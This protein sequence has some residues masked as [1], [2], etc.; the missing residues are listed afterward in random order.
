MSQLLDGW[1]QVSLSEVARFHRGVSYKKNESSDH[2]Q[3]GF[4]PIL[5][6]NNIQNG[7][8]ILDDLVYVPEAKVKETQ[9]ILAGDIVVAMSSGSKRLVGKSGISQKKLNASFGTFCGLLRP[10]DSVDSRYVG[11][12]TRTKYYQDTIS[13]LSKGVNINNLKPKHFDEVLIPLAPKSEQKRVADKLDSIF[14]KMEMAQSRL[15]KVPQL[16]KRFR[17]SVLSAAVAGELTE[18]WRDANNADDWSEIKVT[19]IVEK[20]EAGKNLKCHERPPRED[21]LGIVKISAVTWGVYDEEESKTL[22]DSSLFLENRRI[23]VGDFLISRANTLEL[24]GMPVIVHQVTKNLMLSDK[25][26]RIIAEDADKQWLSIFLRSP[27]GRKQIE[28]RATGNQESMRNIAQKA[29][30]DIDLPMPSPEEKEVIVSIVNGLF[31]K[32]D[33]VEKQYLVAK[34]RVDKLT[35]SILA[36]A[37]RGELFEPFTDKADRVAQTQ[38][39]DVIDEQ[40]AAAE[41]TTL[42]QRDKSLTQSQPTTKAVNDKSE[43]LAQLKSVKNAMTVQQLFESVPGD[44]FK[45]IDELFIEVKRLLE[46]NLVEK[47][48]E[49]ENCQ[50]K[51]TK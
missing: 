28:S 37:F 19:N 12:F 31:G 11:Y 14:E 51:A 2:K 34:Q 3:D 42:E 1:S 4:I 33:L 20:I 41:E 15:D 6:A 17:M 47:V 48:G 13:E 45:A 44:T 36:R 29:F 26:W 40:S 24:L 23:N 49:G 27:E 50:F 25:V 32:A 8:L 10:T 38:S 30:L 5:R 21:E 43:L 7:K 46:L 18:E 22:P 35:Q 39:A 16:L 9:L